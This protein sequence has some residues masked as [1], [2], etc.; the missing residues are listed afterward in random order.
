MVIHT[1]EHEY[2]VTHVREIDSSSECYI[3]RNESAGGLCRILAISDKSLYGD[4]IPGLAD[5]AENSAFT[6]FIEH[7]IFDD[8]LCIVMGY[9]QGVTLHDRLDTESYALAEKLELGRRILERMILCELPDYYLTKCADASSIIVDSDM[10]LHFNYEIDD[11]K[12]AHT[13]TREGAMEKVTELLRFL[14]AKEEENYV[15]AELSEFLG[16]LPQH[17]EAGDLVALYS[18]YHEMMQ[19]ASADDAKPAG[20]DS[21]WHRLWEKLKKLGGILRRI[22][23]IL[24][25]IA[26]ALYLIYTIGDAKNDGTKHT[27]FTKIGTVE[28]K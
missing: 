11:I 21:V 2:P 17:T 18:A 13:Y 16:Q 19:R 1:F 22:L 6:D 5:A 25:L 23:M 3:C 14:F 4:I 9:T 26:A 10:T 8:M 24:L 20:E 27:N 12:D 7:F 15:S 28:I